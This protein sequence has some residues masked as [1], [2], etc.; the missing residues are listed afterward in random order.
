MLN[1]K[2]VP[3]AVLIVL[4]VLAGMMLLTAP[5]TPAS[6][7]ASA[8]RSAQRTRPASQRQKGAVAKPTPPREIHEILG[9]P[10][11]PPPLPTP[12]PTPV[13][14]EEINP[15]DV[16]SVTTTEVM[17]PVTVRD[18]SGRFA[19]DLK[20][21]DFRVFE[22]GR[23][24]PLS[25][26]ALRQVPVD[27]VLMVDASSS[28]ATNI[29]DFR[30]AADGFANRLSTDDRISL[31]KFDDRI[32]LLQDWTK[33]R[34]QL[35]R[36]L[37]RIEPGMFT[38]F[39]DALTLAARQQFVDSKSRRAVIV[40]SDGIDS[41][42]GVSI[43][44]AFKAL[45]AA[46]VVVYVVSN[47]EIARATKLAE[48]DSLLNGGDAAMRFNQL[49][50]DDLR[51]GLRVLDRSEQLLAQLTAGTGGRLYRPQSFQAL[52]ATYAEVAEELRHQYALYYTP[53]NKAR[54]GGFRRVRVETMNP[55][56]QPHTRVGYF[57]PKT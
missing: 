12:T 11:P 4:L 46:Q 8:Q 47:T 38:R 51:E 28:V 20:R 49:R 50:I 42:R 35:R 32:Q 57:A 54:D 23:E 36:A 15:G 33:S 52:E 39:N 3:P 25:D 26:L 56:Y 34:F 45:L 13:P 7:I 9:E 24:Q 37:T 55:N 27:V 43:E 29:D 16:I 31:I 40:L 17:L 41:G 44:N 18:A 1:P 22:D 21:E 30:R 2:S 6:L 19:N 14:K 10:P 53:L 48:L 5:W